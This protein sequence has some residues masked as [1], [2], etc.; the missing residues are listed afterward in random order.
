MK[1]F[2]RFVVVCLVFILGWVFAIDGDEELLMSQGLAEDGEFLVL[3]QLLEASG[4]EGELAGLGPVTMFVPTD[5]VFERL[6]QN[7]LV[8]LLLDRERVRGVLDAHVVR[9]TYSALELSNAEPG[10]IVTLRGEPLVFD[11]GALSGLRVNGVEIDDPDNVFADGVVHGVEGLIVPT[12]IVAVREP[13]AAEVELE[14]ELLVEPEVEPEAETPLVMEPQPVETGGLIVSVNPAEASVNIIGPGGFSERLSGEVALEGLE[15][16]LYIVTATLAGYEVARDRVEVSSGEVAEVALTL[17][18]RATL[19]PA[20][21]VEVED[22]PNFLFDNSR[23][24]PVEAKEELRLAENEPNFLFDNSRRRITAERPFGNAVVETYELRGGREGA[25]LLFGAET[26][27]GIPNV[28]VTGPNGFSETLEAG[29]VVLEDLLP[30]VYYLAA[31]E[32]DYQL[33]QTAVD[34]PA[35]AAVPVFLTLSDLDAP[36]DLGGLPTYGGYGVSAYQPLAVTDGETGTLTLLTFTDESEIN[37]VGPDGYIQHYGVDV[38]LDGLRP[39]PYAVAATASGY[40]V[41]AGIVEVRAGQEVE[42]SVRL[43]PLR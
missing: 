25:L 27:S 20:E 38:S 5:E 2:G 13:V 10:S 11:I 43:E 15:P 3:L 23:E 35:G 42:V 22:E 33:V 18:P 29:E 21:T 6:G 26:E 19:A 32:E 8:A 34:V 24:T 14:V 7:E 39:G 17:E 41:S 36:Y 1:E 31:T 28:L 30:G 37:V 4:L 40:E 12:D 9:G 16:G